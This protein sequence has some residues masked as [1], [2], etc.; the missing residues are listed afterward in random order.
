MVMDSAEHGAGRRIGRGGGP[1][2]ETGR[3]AARRRQP[4][5]RDKLL[6]AAIKEFAAKG[7]EGARVDAIALRAGSNKNMIYHYFGSKD[8]LFE[9]VLE[10]MYSTIRAHQSRLAI[11][12]L[13]PR[14]AI[15]ALVEM[16]F[17]VFAKHPEFISLLSSE[18]LVKAQHVRNS[19]KIRNMYNPLIS[20]IETIL[21]TGVKQ[22]IF[23]PGL[24]AADLYISISAL[25]NYHI[26]NRYTLSALFGF[27]VNGRGYRVQRRN[28]AVEMTLRYIQADGAG[29]G[30]PSRVPTDKG[31]MTVPAGKGLE[32]V[33]DR[34]YRASA[35]RRARE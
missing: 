10:Q 29:H 30:A 1:T 32:G 34:R 14:S 17:E 21:E 4:L 15:A 2:S 12:D 33:N 35:S 11:D 16:T 31:R 18:N 7:L 6:K 13:E 3:D 26:S 22:D 27:D 25:A 8:G 9:A 20:A 23:R 19:Q 5:T 24:S 28:H